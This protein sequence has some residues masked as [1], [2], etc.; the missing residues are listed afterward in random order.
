[1]DVTDSVIY[2]FITLLHIIYLYGKF[3]IWGTF[4]I[5]DNNYKN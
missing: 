4:T 1:M 3:Y 5:K 2:R